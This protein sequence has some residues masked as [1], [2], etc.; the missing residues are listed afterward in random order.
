LRIAH[1]PDRIIRFAHVQ[2]ERI[3][4][5]VGLASLF[6]DAREHEQVVCAGSFAS[7]RRLSRAGALGTMRLRNMFEH[8]AAD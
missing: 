3:D 8:L 5:F 2:K 1:P 4:S 7:E 6:E